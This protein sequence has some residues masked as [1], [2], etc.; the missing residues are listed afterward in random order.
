LPPGFAKL[1]AIMMTG[2]VAVF[3]DTT[4]V[5]VAIDSLSSHL[6]TTVATTQWAITGY[7]LAMGVVIPLAGWLMD[8]V[9]GWSI[10]TGA[11]S[12]GSASRSAQPGCF[13][14]G[15]RVVFVGWFGFRVTGGPAYVA[16]APRSA[17]TLTALRHARALPYLT[18]RRRQ[19]IR[20]TLLDLHSVTLPATPS[21]AA[22]IRSRIST[23]DRVEDPELFTERGAICREQRTS[24]NTAQGADVTSGAT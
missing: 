20:S 9:G 10:G 24:A 15:S 16:G 12:S 7:V 23:V 3:L 2:I 21:Q 5:N 13:C 18:R 17:A 8:R 22:L 11:E 4:I 6:H 1:A 14:C 19:R